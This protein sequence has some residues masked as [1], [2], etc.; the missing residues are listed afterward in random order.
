MIIKIGIGLL[1]ATSIFIYFYTNNNTRIEI[2]RKMGKTKKDVTFTLIP[3]WR[4]IPSGNI[5]IFRANGLRLWFEA[6]ERDIK[7]TRPEDY[8]NKIAGDKKNGKR[9]K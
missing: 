1:I 6:L 4:G 5:R 8:N 7:T 3:F 2:V 9:N